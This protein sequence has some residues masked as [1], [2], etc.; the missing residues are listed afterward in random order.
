MRK[1]YSWTCFHFYENEF[2][3]CSYGN[4]KA[5]TDN[6]VNF[7]QLGFRNKNKGCAG[8]DV[9]RHRFFVESYAN[10]YRSLK[11]SFIRHRWEVNHGYA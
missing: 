4:K 5:L 3:F 8:W 1:P 10:R 2:Q 7:C 9:D 6:D 11:N